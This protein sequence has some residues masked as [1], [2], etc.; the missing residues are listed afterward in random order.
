MTPEEI[1]LGL[2]GTFQ[3]IDNKIC[4]YY[5]VRWCG[6]PYTFLGKYTRNEL[7]PPV[8]IPKDSLVCEKYSGVL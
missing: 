6:I 4:G 1:E 3:N 2:F 5:I 8:V 7:N